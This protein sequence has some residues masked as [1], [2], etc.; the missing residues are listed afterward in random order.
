MPTAYSKELPVFR[1]SCP[2]LPV[3]HFRKACASFGC[4]LEA[5]TPPPEIAD[6]GAR[7]LVPEIVQRDIVAVLA[8]LGLIAEVVVVVDHGALDLAGIDGL[9]RV[10]LPG[11]RVAFSF[12]ALSQ[13][14]VAASPLSSSRRRRWPGNRRPTARR[15]SGPSS[16][17]RRDRAA[18]S[19]ACRPSA[20]SCCR[21]RRCVRAAM[22]IQRP[23]AGRKFSGTCASV[24][25][26][27][28]ANRPAVVDQRHGR[29]VL[30]QEHVGRR[31]GAFLRRSGCANS[32]VAAVAEGHLDA[33]V[34]GEAVRPRL[35][36]AL[37][38]GVVDD[39]AVG[40]LGESGAGGTERRRGDSGQPEKRER[41]YHH[42][43]PNRGVRRAAT[44]AALW[45]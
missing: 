33:G 26:S 42:V 7:I 4:L 44:L 24:S 3:I 38:L 8:G 5:S 11:R 28:G 32:H 6:E 12:M 21:R 39:D 35:G 19:A 13:A 34:L 27:T 29:R 15:P 14:A 2:P 18:T 30:G 31:G 40:R 36:Q 1:M 22:P 9:H 10:L 23:L 41:R 20:W 45:V 37:V 43:G 17:D 25:A 16:S